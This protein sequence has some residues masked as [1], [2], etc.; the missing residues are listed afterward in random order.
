MW[1][2]DFASGMQLFAT[3]MATRYSRCG[4]RAGYAQSCND[5]R[6][7]ISPRPGASLQEI[8][9]IVIRSPEQTC[10]WSGRPLAHD[11]FAV[12]QPTEQS[13]C[14]AVFAHRPTSAAR[15]V[16][17]AL[18]PGRRGIPRHKLCQRQGSFRAPREIIRQC[19]RQSG[20]YSLTGLPTSGLQWCLC[21]LLRHR[22]LFSVALD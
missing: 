5:I 3:T 6:H 19:G 22:A 13:A 11:P 9:L 15:R 21:C 1:L 4:Y 14:P 2:A 20:R 7:G 18:M 16:L 12:E 10:T 17:A 8:P